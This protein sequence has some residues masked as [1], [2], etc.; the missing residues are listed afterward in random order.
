MAVAS[1]GEQLGVYESSSLIPHVETGGISASRQ[2]EH[3][4]VHERTTSRLYIS[5]FL[6]TWNSRVFE[7]GAVLYLASIYP[8]TLLPMSVYALSRGVATILFAPAVGHYIDTGERLRVVRSSIVWQ[9]LVVIA[10]CVIFYLLASDIP[11]MQKGDFYLLAILALLACVEKLCSITN[12][13][14]VERDWV[15]VV[16]GEDH[17]SLTMM[18]AQMRRIDLICKL[19][20][21]LFIALIDGISTKTAI[22]VN[23]GMNTCSVVFEYFAIA[24]VYYDVPEL[25]IPKGIS[26]NIPPNV[27]SERHSF[28]IR[29]WGSCRNITQKA[30]SDFNFYFHHAVFL[31]SFAGALLYL[32]VLSFGGQMVTWLLAAGYSSA[33]VAITRTL[34]VIFEVLATWIAPWLMGRIWPTRAGLWL[35]NWQIVCLGAGFSIFWRFADYP[36]ISASGLV[37]GTILSRI[38]LRGFEL[39]ADLIVQ[40]G[41][42]AKARGAF[43]STEA[44]WQSFFEICSY[45]S[46]II[47]FHPDQFGWPALISVVAVA[48]AGIQYMVFVWVQRGHLVHL[49]NCLSQDRLRRS[50]EH[51]L[52]RILSSADL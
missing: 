11:T 37:G 9:R 10:S 17:A 7:F 40:E 44:A 39:C 51:G 12:M 42:E 34:S 14:S 3:H 31:P 19:F 36:F 2:A 24:R 38:G 26:S 25:Q 4:R 6:S 35:A 41:V 30:L 5:H 45:I 32:T 28:V 52:E 33:H 43:S 13:I 50:R 29:I 8:H 21:P 20:G 22:L 15:V 16:A 49:P 46:T 18:N 48:I 27:A 47:F 23:L 1:S